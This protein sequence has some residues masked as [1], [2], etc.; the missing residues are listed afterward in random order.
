MSFR[1][2]LSDISRSTVF[3]TLCLTGCR[4]TLLISLI[5]FT[6]LRSEV[7]CTASGNSVHC[8]ICWFRCNRMV[9]V[10]HRCNMTVFSF[11]GFVL[12]LRRRIGC[13]LLLFLSVCLSIDRNRHPWKQLILLCYGH[14]PHSELHLMSYPLPSRDRIIR[15]NDY[16]S[17]AVPLNQTVPQLSVSTVDNVSLK[18]APLHCYWHGSARKNVWMK[19][20]LLAT[21]QWPTNL[22]HGPK[23]QI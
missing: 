8:T 19:L 6:F 16:F 17:L 7:V 9:C 10:L 2:Y 4:T 13:F 23:R 5:C 3:F 11:W 1:K 18:T 21:V 12:F 15:Q 22:L 14:L 20:R